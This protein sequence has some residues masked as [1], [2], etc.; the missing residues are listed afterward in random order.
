MGVVDNQAERARAGQIRTQPVQAV[1]DR[2][3]GIDARRGA[4]VRSW[5]TWKPEEGGRHAGSA[6]QQIGALQL[7][8]LGQRPLEELTHHSEGEIAL[9]LGSP[10][11]EHA[12]PA[13]CRRRPRLRE[14]RRLANPGRPFDHKEPPAARASLGQRRLDPRQLLVS[15]E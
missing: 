10:R 14:Q 11:P 2:E 6:V 7:R 4:A 5:S 9:Q 13:L 8:C 1:Q 15:L 12:H 3:R